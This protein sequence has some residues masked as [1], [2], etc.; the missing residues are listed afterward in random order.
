M[1]KKLMFI[2]DSDLYIR[3]YFETGFIKKL[4]KI[5]EIF[6]IFS[7]EVNNKNFIKKNKNFL[8]YYST[9]NLKKRIYY[10]F[11]NILLW[12][13][14]NRSTS[15]QFRFYRLLDFHGF[16]IKINIKKSFKI[17][18][19]IIKIYTKVFSINFFFK[20]L[21]NLLNNKIFLNKDISNYIDKVKP[22]LVIYPTNA[23][24]PIVSEIPIICK[25]Q[26]IKSYFLIDNWDNLSSKSILMNHP[27]YISVW[28]KQTANHAKK[29]QNISP[30]KIFING[31]PRY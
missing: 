11:N 7:D 22:D 16:P 2:I 29:I 1:K 13:F 24:E 23:F 18:T 15:F 20:I 3:N 21:K 28:G 6:F 26:K 9:S 19:L 12:K 5:Y 31:T 8:G 17:R 14:R 30:K 27:D 25:N 10:L 4:S